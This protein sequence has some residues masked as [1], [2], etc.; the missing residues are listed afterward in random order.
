MIKQIVAQTLGVFFGYG[1]LQMLFAAIS[2]IEREGFSFA[3]VGLVLIIVTSSLTLLALMTW[4]VC[5]VWS[6]FKK[7]AESDRKWF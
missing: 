6:D 7:G 3:D 1:L 4:V 5:T 2:Y